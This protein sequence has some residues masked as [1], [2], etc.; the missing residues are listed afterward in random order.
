MFIGLIQG[1]IK[2][3]GVPEARNKGREKALENPAFT[4]SDIEG[5]GLLWILPPRLRLLDQKGQYGL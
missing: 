2:V 1:I 4:G 3:L 5:A